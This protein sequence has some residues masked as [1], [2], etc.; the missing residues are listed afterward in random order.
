[1]KRLHIH[2]AVE[3]LNKSI[4]FYSTM[5]G[6]EPTVNREDYAKWCL[7]DPL[8]NFAIS[9]NGKKVGL[10]HL[11]IQ[12]DSEEALDLIKQAMVATKIDLNEEHDAS[13][14]Y[15]HSHKHWTLDPQG[16]AWETFVTFG[17][18]KSHCAGGVEVNEGAVSCCVP[19]IMG[20]TENKEEGKCCVSTPGS[21]CCG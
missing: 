20:K 21:D 6:S 3:D 8:V 14:C 2:L 13:C 15:A 4:Q 11:G 19:T 18:S 16:I 9:F 5:F 10:D 17:D 12:V 1:M 7:D